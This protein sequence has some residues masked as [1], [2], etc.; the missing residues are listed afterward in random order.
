MKRSLLSIAFLSLFLFGSRASADL[1]GV[2]AGAVAATLSLP[3]EDVDDASG[4]PSI[5]GPLTVRGEQTKP[6]V[7]NVAFYDFGVFGMPSTEPIQ[8][9]FIVHNGGKTT[10]IIDRAEPGCECTTASLGGGAAGPRFLAPNQDLI[11][12]VT[13]DSKQ[14]YVGKINK[15]IW[16]YFSGQSSP[17]YTLHVVGRTIPTAVFTPRMLEFG[18]AHAGQLLARTLTVSADTTAYGDHPPDPYSIH[19]AVTIVRDAAQATVAGAQRIRTYRVLLSKNA[20]QGFLSEVIAM[21]M[22]GGAHQP[23]PSILVSGVVLA[24]APHGPPPKAKR[25]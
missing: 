15:I 2:P 21:P 4:A 25:R 10:L 12:H 18:A 24:D 1:T 9:D 6:N 14:L 17:A 5:P 20:K 11:I 3:G 13:I 16:I 22:A 7:P 8:H 23:G 19:G